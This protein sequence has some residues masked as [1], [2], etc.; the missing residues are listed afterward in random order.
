MNK[1]HQKRMVIKA[2]FTDFSY[3]IV[4]FIGTF[5]FYKCDLLLYWIISFY[6]FLAAGIIIIT[7]RDLKIIENDLGF[8]DENNS[9]I[10]LFKDLRKYNHEVN[11]INNI[12][13]F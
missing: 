1:I 5:I 11:E 3:F 12:N 8:F 4:W 2:L 10:V 9:R 13:K 7:R 6:I